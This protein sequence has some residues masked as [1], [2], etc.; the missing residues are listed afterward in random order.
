MKSAKTRKRKIWVG[1]VI[2]FWLAVGVAV[3]LIFDIT[4]DEVQFDSADVVAA[5]R[6][7]FR[8]TSTLLLD[9]KS[10]ATISGG[11][12]GMAAPKGTVLT[13]ESAAALL[14]SGDALLLLDNGELT[15]GS[16]VGDESPASAPLARALQQGLFKALAL[17]KSTIIVV[18]PNGHRERLTGANIQMVP[19][20]D[21][22]VEAK[23]EGFWRGQRSKFSLKTSAAAKN[24]SVPI[25]F[26]FNATLLDFTYDGTLRL[27]DQLVGASAVLGSAVV[28][29]KDTERLANALGTSW[30]IGTSV[31][32]ISIE[33]PLRWKADTLAFDQAKVRV[34]SNDAE[35]T[36]S[37]KTAGGQALISSTLAF[38]KLD[39]APYLPSGATDRTA[40]AW[41]WWS[42][43]VGTLSQPAAP[44]I[45]ADIRLSAKSLSS[46]PHALGPAAA[47][48]SMKDGK[49]SAD[50]AEIT[51]SNG[52]ATGQISI[53]FNRY[54]PKLTLRGQLEE[55]ATG[56][57]L[58]TLTG[59]R[60]IE[61]QG[62]VI[63]ELSSQGVSVQQ[64][65][66]D[67]AGTVEFAVPENG[68]IALSLVELNNA[69]DKS[70]LQTTKET[71]ARVMRGSTVVN[72]LEAVLKLKDGVANVVK[73][74]AI[75]AAGSVKASGSFDLMRPIYD[76][77]MLSLVGVK[78]PAG[79]EKS[80]GDD[81]KEPAAK[82]ASPKPPIPAA[83]TLVAV[84]SV[85]PSTR[86][87]GRL[88]TA[89]AGQTGFEVPEIQLRALTGMLKELERFLGPDYS[90]I[91]R[92][93]L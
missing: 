4:G 22:T 13:A 40:L 75:H 27:S 60:Y 81:G 49:L 89:T 90:H 73:A 55:I 93:G 61:G 42:K 3:P 36:V 7:Q 38:D 48:V 25:E 92:R 18:L 6:D 44:H 16:Q 65:I 84:K 70:Q 51:L 10:G 64:I 35:G 24:G 72:E 50:I 21:G 54:I 79:D 52:R 74:S 15:V 2:I 12:L 32:D 53:D 30:P 41:Q 88:D 58:E 80:T 8:I 20:D 71:L 46:G 37:L 5:P 63:A 43:L 91:P 86:A 29:L 56:K 59:K 17:R 14:K 11:T 66:G 9:R 68:A 1:A 83:A 26:A 28:H 45:N 34:G 85:K 33:G 57:W 87:I 82:A 23:G 69:H 78:T 62:R 76:F 19:S 77:R 47:T 31:Q 67:L 39:I